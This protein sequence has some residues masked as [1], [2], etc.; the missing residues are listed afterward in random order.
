[1]I[2]CDTSL[3]ELYHHGIKGQ[4]WGVR[5]FQ[6]EDGSLTSEG[7]RRYSDS[8]S[9]IYGDGDGDDDYTVS[10]GTTVARRN[11]SNKDNS[12]DGEKYTYTYDFDNLTDD[13]FYKQFGKKVTE[14]SLV[15][16]VVLAGRTA[17]GKAFADKMLTL[18]D[19]NEIEAMDTL[20]YD[21]RRR[22][23]KNYVSDLFELPYEPSKHREA[24]EIAGAD[25][26]ARMLSK[27]QRPWLD[28]EMRY[29]GKRDDDT[30]ANEIGRSIV[31][32]LLSDG[33]SGMRDYNDYGSAAPVTTPTIFF[34][35]N[36]KL[37]QL[38]V[39]LDD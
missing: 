32:Q 28:E 2:T 27:K 18:T 8:L 37:S 15:D 20:Y 16:D 22:L 13:N 7:E 4:K 6:N 35:P 19:E 25:M 12:I 29:D 30:V 39:W 33:Y 1:M 31:D 5:R 23:G 38:N 10:K 24:L 9:N 21:A 17:L 34:D 11:P 26:V 3:D 14:Y 36:M